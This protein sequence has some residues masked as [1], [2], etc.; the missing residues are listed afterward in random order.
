MIRG[1]AG[2]FER[3]IRFIMP[4]ASG[5]AVDIVVRIGPAIRS[6][7][8]CRLR[9]VKLRHSV[10]A[11]HRDLQQRHHSVGADRMPLSQL[12]NLLRWGECRTSCRSLL[13]AHP[14]ER[15]DEAD[16]D[17]VDPNPG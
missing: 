13:I 10:L 8:H 9:A 6:T 14:K 3:A 5:G 2:S 1:S 7:G 12:A 16:K 4:F 15:L 17:S 11:V